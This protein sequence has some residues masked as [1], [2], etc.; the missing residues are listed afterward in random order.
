MYIEF[1]CELTWNTARVKFSYESHI[2]HSTK[3]QS[4]LEGVTCPDVIPSQSTPVSREP[5]DRKR[6]WS[7]YPNSSRQ[8]GCFTATRRP[9]C[10][11]PPLLSAFLDAVMSCTGNRQCATKRKKSGRFC[12]FPGVMEGTKHGKSS[13]LSQY[14]DHRLFYSIVLPP[15]YS[16]ERI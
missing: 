14:P 1:Y 12:H 4:H 7:R 9:N 6:I 8:P 13:I 10:Q 5:D 11:V 16:A 2:F 3:I 15:S